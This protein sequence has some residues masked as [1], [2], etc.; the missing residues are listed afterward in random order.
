MGF[1]V[2]T[3]IKNPPANSGDT[4]VSGSIPGFYIHLPR[5]D[6]PAL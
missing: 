1:P 3:V 4:G 6:I 2:G 5:I